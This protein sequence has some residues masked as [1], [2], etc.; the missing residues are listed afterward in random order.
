MKFKLNAGAEFDILTQD[1]LAKSLKRFAQDW[2]VEA[3]RG[4]K[5]VDWWGS[6]TVTAAGALTIGGATMDP[7]SG[8]MGPD[9]SMIWSVKRWNVQSLVGNGDSLH[10]WVDVANPNRSIIDG[11]SGYNRFGSDE[12]IVRGGSRILFTGATLATPVGTVVTVAGS[13][14]ELPATMMYR[15]M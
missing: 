7:A 11:V 10:A 12:L 5:V 9:P 13:A 1:E 3:A 8:H 15:L 6:G 2:Q 4:P 14:W